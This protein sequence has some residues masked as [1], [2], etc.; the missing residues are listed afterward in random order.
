VK[1][2]RKLK[3]W[4]NPVQVFDLAITGPDL[5]LQLFQRFEKFR[6]I[7]FG[8]DGSVGWVLSAVDRFNLH[9]KTMLGVVP[10]GTGNDMARVMGWGATF[11]DEEKL[12]LILREM[13]FSSF[14]LL[15]RWSIQYSRGDV[16]MSPI[17]EASSPIPPKVYRSPLLLPRTL[18][19]PPPLPGPHPSSA[20]DND[21]PYSPV[22]IGEVFE[23]DSIDRTGLEVCQLSDPA[24]LCELPSPA[25]SSPETDGTITT[26]TSGSVGSFDLIVSDLTQILCSRDEAT[27]IS[28]AQS[29][30]FP[31]RVLL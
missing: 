21:P 17:A 15:D 26:T 25:D 13:E 2:L 20:P 5:G 7:V 4:L 29:V 1:F 11:N 3:Y 31:L 19:E 23:A 28:S 16:D 12:P 10:L 27:V 14:H 18:E 9:S 22:N 30:P 6:I 8:G 24:Q